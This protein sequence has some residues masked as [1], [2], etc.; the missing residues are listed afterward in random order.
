MEFIAVEE[1]KD[2]KIEAS[3]FVL[4]CSFA[5]RS[6]TKG[7]QLTKEELVEFQEYGLAALPCLPDGLSRF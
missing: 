6:L 3:V 1:Q 4:F 7:S 2:A 5:C